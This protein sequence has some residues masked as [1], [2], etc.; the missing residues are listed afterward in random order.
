VLRAR[1]S[2]SR[3][4]D[5]IAARSATSLSR[6]AL[7]HLFKAQAQAGDRRLQIMR[8]GGQNMGALTKAVAHALLHQVEGF[9]RHA[10][11]AR[12]GH[13]DRLGIA[14]ERETLRRVGQA[15]QR[16]GGQPRCPEGNQRAGH[17][18]QEQIDRIERAIMR[19][20][21]REEVDGDQPP[22]PAHR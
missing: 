21:Q 5:C 3:T 14:G 15:A 12:A 8:D 4:S 11:F 20:L 18:D 2:P 9:Q 22:H 13:R 16:H 1:S 10:H 7:L 19:D 17:H 6:S